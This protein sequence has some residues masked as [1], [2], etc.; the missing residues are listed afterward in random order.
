MHLFIQF[1][2]CKEATALSWLPSKLAT[3]VRCVL[4][5]IDETPQHQTLKSRPNKPTELYVTPLD[6]ASREVRTHPENRQ[7]REGTEPFKI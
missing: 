7:T 6:M 1:D 3:Q 4:S 2:E 5:M